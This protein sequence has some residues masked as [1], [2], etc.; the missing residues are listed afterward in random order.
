M[1]TVLKERHR[2]LRKGSKISNRERLRYLELTTLRE[3]RIRGDLI[4]T[5]KIMTG[6]E[7]VDRS[8]FNH[9]AVE[10]INQS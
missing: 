7:R 6:K 3:Q 5:F 8:Q 1:V 9:E 10:A 2:V 4:E